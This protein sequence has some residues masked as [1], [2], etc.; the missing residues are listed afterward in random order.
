M[1]QILNRDLHTEAQQ[2]SFCLEKYLEQGDAVAAET[3]VYP[4]RSYRA[5]MVLQCW[6]TMKSETLCPHINNWMQAV[7][8]E[9]QKLGQGDSLLQRVIPVEGLT[10][11]HHQA[12]SQQLGEGE[13]WSKR[14]CLC[15]APLH[16]YCTKQFFCCEN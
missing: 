14:G 1:K 8:W 11:N 15:N 7:P 13:L 12:Y 4:T 16:H 9:G 10:M 6:H 3:S 5:R 2:R